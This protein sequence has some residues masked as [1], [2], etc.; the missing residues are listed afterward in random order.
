ML[1]STSPSRSGH[2]QFR[3][4]LVRD[5]LA[6]TPVLS[7]LASALYPL[8]GG[9]YHNGRADLHLIVEI[10][11]ALVGHAGRE[12]GRRM[13]S[14]GC[15]GYQMVKCTKGPGP[16]VKDSAALERRSETAP[17]HPDGAAARGRN[18]AASN[19][20]SDGRL[21]EHGEPRAYGV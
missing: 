10:N 20:R 5:T 15:F 2:R 14:L 11:R 17:A 7:G 16:S 6:V 12:L 1:A 8:P 19:C 3:E 9:K 13:A 18:D 4:P 21:A